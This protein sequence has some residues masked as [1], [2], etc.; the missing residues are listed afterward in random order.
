L[1]FERVRFGAL[2]SV[3]FKVD[4]VLEQEAIPISKAI[5]K[6]DLFMFSVNLSGEIYIA[7]TIPCN[8]NNTNI[9]RTLDLNASSRNN[10]D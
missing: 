10:L 9:N 5:K 2:S 7:I 4:C 1:S 6:I 3:F 8:L